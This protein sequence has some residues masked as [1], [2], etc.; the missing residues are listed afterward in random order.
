[1]GEWNLKI[2]QQDCKKNST[3]LPNP[4]LFLFSRE[5]SLIFSSLSPL[6]SL[7]LRVCDLRPCHRRVSCRLLFQ[8]LY[9]SK[10]SSNLFYSRHQ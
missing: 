4:A 6:R 3:L 8:L 9:I 7:Q 1:M 10:H 2:L 5:V